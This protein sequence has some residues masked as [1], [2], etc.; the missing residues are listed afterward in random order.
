MNNLIDRLK[1]G[2]CRSH[3][4]QIREVR[5]VDDHIGAWRELGEM[6]DDMPAQDAACPGYQD[7][8]GRTSR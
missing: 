6:P 4:I 5:L 3:R 2:D 7:P 8:H 1:G